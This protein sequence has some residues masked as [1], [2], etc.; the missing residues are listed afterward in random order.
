MIH[1]RGDL[2]ARSTSA[3]E[4]NQ[5]EIGRTLDKVSCKRRSI[6]RDDQVTLRPV[7]VKTEENVLENI[8]VSKSVDVSKMKVTA[9]MATSAAKHFIATQAYDADVEKAIE[10][11]E[12]VSLNLGLEGRLSKKRSLPKLNQSSVHVDPNANTFDHFLSLMQPAQCV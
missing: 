6:D 2:W 4:A 7:H 11:R 8:D 12:I 9:A 10:M 1:E 5:A 3:L